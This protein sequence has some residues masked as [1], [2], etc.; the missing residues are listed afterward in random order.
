MEALNT[1]VNNFWFDPIGNRT[2]IHCFSSLRS[3]VFVQ[4]VEH[5]VL[6]S[7]FCNPS[8]YTFAVVSNNVTHGNVI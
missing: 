3:L 7:H 8:P 4:L 1:K 5:S 6:D 2:P